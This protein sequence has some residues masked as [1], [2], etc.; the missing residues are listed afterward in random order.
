MSD[1]EET[2]SKS[3]NDFP[4]S[5]S[6]RD[7][8]NSHVWNELGNVY[9]NAGAYDAA[10]SAYQKAIELDSEFAWAYS[11][12]A[13]IYTRLN[14][15][16]LAIK[17]YR[18]SID[19][20]KSDEEKAKIW[21]RLGNAYRQT[22]D[23]E[24]ALAA[25]KT[26]DELSDNNLSDDDNIFTS[27]KESENT[28]TSS[29]NNE[30]L[31]HNDSLNERKKQVLKKGTLFRDIADNL[32]MFAKWTIAS[33]LDGAFVA[34]WV[35]VQYGFNLVIQHFPL[36]G[37]DMWVLRCFQILFAITTITPVIFYIYEDIMVMAYKTAKRVH[38]EKQR[39]Q[40]Q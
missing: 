13:L 24:N 11:N 32:R 9:L 29:Q 21:N 8:Q 18:Q 30:E 14:L 40:L 36:Q 37:V 34:F 15:T 2:P 20:F 6:T 4:G 16:D 10:I 26:A 3:N 27:G 22:N 31:I 5:Q 1:K 19:L 23:Y 17:H 38:L 28:S 39:S 25:Y 7:T 12:L 35:L 33:L